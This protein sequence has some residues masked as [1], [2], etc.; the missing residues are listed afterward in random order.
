M[1]VGKVI[2]VEI[3]VMFGVVMEGVFDVVLVGGEEGEGDGVD[4]VFDVERS[5]FFVVFDDGVM[6]GERCGY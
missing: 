4:D 3:V 1:G 5:G 2:F 6:C